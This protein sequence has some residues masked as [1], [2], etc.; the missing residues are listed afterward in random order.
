MSNNLN[1]KLISND[2]QFTSSYI[3]NY[4]ILNKQNQSN[5]AVKNYSDTKI[6]KK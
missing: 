5:Q 4:E 6:N 1:K 3:N 2:L